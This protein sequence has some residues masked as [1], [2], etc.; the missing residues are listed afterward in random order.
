MAEVV[1]ELGINYEALRDWVGA[2]QKSEDRDA[3]MG[4]ETLNPMM[5]AAA[6]ILSS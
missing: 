3:Q 6:A 4:A 2:G 5:R 1:G